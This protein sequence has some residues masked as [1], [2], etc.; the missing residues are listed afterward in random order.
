MANPNTTNY[1]AK[2]AGL[3]YRCFDG[4]ALGDLKKAKYYIDKDLCLP[5]IKITH[6]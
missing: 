3:N 1:K 2:K 5:M 6:I 4:I